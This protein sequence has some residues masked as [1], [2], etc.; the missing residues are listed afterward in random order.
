[1]PLT[2]ED[3]VNE[4]QQLGKMQTSPHPHLWAPLKPKAMRSF[5][6][7]MLCHRN[8]TCSFTSLVSCITFSV[9]L[10]RHGEK[11]VPS[12]AGCV[13]PQ[14]RWQGNGGKAFLTA[15]LFVVSPPAGA[16]RIR[17]NH[18]YRASLLMACRRVDLMASA[19]R[20]VAETAEK[21]TNALNACLIGLQICSMEFLPCKD[22]W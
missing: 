5:F 20:A 22:C 18:A 21:E 8:S 6:G 10:R 7:K 14:T 1:M 4:W 12:L 17:R 11:S 13:T 2:C 15:G 9:T 19:G 16:R 3:C